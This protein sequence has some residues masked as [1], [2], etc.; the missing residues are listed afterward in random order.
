MASNSCNID[1]QHTQG[2]H[3]QLPLVNYCAGSRSFE[4]LLEEIKDSYNRPRARK[5]LLMGSTESPYSELITHINYKPSPKEVRIFCDL[6]DN[7]QEEGGIAGIDIKWRFSHAND[8][9]DAKYFIITVNGYI[10]GFMITSSVK[11]SDTLPVPLL[12]FIYFTPKFRG[13]NLFDQ[14]YHFLLNDIGPFEVD[15]PNKVCIRALKKRGYDRRQVVAMYL[16]EAE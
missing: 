9:Q 5:K 12:N 14:A 4:R 15:T 7:Y 11:Y 16:K 3:L 1:I 8:H 13:T 10:A 6:Y 2:V